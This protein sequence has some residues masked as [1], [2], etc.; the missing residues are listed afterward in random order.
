MGRL[1]VPKSH[2]SQL[3]WNLP[4]QGHQYWLKLPKE[5]SLQPAW[6]STGCL[7]SLQGPLLSGR[8]PQSFQAAV[9]R[10]AV[11]YLETCTGALFRW[12][13]APPGAPFLHCPPPRTPSSRPLRSASCYSPWSAPPGPT[14]MPA[15][16][17]RR[18][19]RGHI[20]SNLP[21]GSWEAPCSVFCVHIVLGHTPWPNWPF[22]FPV[23][24]FLCSQRLSRIHMHRLESRVGSRSP[25]CSANKCSW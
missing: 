15:D 23:I 2:P 4:G 1:K 17:S 14:W 20:L 16:T 21:Q 12:N 24:L 7:S 5:S 19:V 6:R 10:P 11:L 18:P 9:Q 3:N 25:K 13:L 22:Y 8:P